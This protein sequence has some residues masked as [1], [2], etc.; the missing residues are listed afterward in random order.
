MDGV[1][2]TQIKKNVVVKRATSLNGEKLPMI[3]L[4]FLFLFPIL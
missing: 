1:I 4:E 3:S 2:Y